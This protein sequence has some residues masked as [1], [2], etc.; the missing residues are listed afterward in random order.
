VAAFAAMKREM[1]SGRFAFF[2]VLSQTGLAW[3]VATVVYQVGRLLG[4]G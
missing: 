3:L 4:L 2:T 1:E